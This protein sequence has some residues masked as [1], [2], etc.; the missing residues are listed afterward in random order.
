MYFLSWVIIGLIVGWL[1]GWL[2]KEGG[3]GPVVNN[4][5]GI[6]LAAILGSALASGINA[7]FSTRK[8]YA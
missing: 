7:Y 2:V 4:V 8:R 1:T 5:M 6:G 3:Y